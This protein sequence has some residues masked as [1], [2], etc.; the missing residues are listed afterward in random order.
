MPAQAFTDF[1]KNMSQMKTPAPDVAEITA[2]A[3][4][5]MEAMNA[6]GKVVAESAQTAARRSM[7]TMRQ[8]MESAIETS[9]E[10]FTGQS[11]EM[12]ITRQSQF[13]RTA[14]EQAMSSLREMSDLFTKSSFE[15]ASMLQKRMSDSIAEL[16]DA[17]RKQ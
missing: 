1:Y 14:M 15:A 4:R 13:A 2:T 7:D 6:A 8:G 10:I 9:R 5:N 17:A 16:Q 11:P 3:R 12:N